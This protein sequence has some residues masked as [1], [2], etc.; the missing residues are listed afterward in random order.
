VKRLINTIALAVSASV[1]CR[2][3]DSQTVTTET[4]ESSRI[5]VLVAEGFS[6]VERGS[7]IEAEYRMFTV[8]DMPGFCA[9]ENPTQLLFGSVP[10]PVAGERMIYSGFEVLALNGAQRIIPRVPFLLS[11]EQVQ[12]AVLD[13]TTTAAVS[14]F[15]GLSAI[16]AGSFLIKVE[17]A[18]ETPE[19]L[20][21]RALVTVGRPRP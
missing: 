7:G 17:A 15:A 3:P 5:F 9:V 2:S 1:G 8:P 4:D 13:L 20:E 10:S 6:S 21:A 18:C 16:R 19:H 14:E 12:P 11:V